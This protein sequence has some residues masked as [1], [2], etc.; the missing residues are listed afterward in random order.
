VDPAAVAGSLRDHLDGRVTGYVALVGDTVISGGMARRDTDPP[1][2]PMGPEVMAN[3]ASVGKVFTTVVL[4]QALARHGLDVDTAIGPY[5]PP[6]WV[7]G[8]NVETVTFRDLL[9]HRSGFRHD[10]TRIFLSEAA[11]QEQI[12]L[13]IGTN[14]HGLFQYNNINFS[15]VRDLALTGISTSSSSRPGRPDSRP[16]SARTPACR[17]SSSSTHPCLRRRWRRSSPRPS[18][19]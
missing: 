6:E 19:R 10:S 8:P 15:I 17:W 1:A 9:T 13:G 3:T 4:L 7:R 12:A 11:A 2:L 14:V 16:T 18:P 5:L